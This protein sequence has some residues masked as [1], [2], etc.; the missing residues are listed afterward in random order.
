MRRTRRRARSIRRGVIITLIAKAHRQ[1]VLELE[2]SRR[3]LRAFTAND[4]IG[5]EVVGHDGRIT[6][7]ASGTAR[8]SATRAPRAQAC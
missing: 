1:I 4:E 6:W 7:T 2:R 5:L 8:L 3:Q